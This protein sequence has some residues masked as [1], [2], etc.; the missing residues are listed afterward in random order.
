MAHVPS[1]PCMI[2]SILYS[3]F[4]TPKT[5][6]DLR[7]TTPARASPTAQNFLNFILLFWKIW[8]NRRLAPPP[9]DCR[10]LLWG[11]LGPSLQKQSDNF[12]CIV[13]I[14]ERSSLLLMAAVG[15]SGPTPPYCSRPSN[16][17]EQNRTGT[18]SMLGSSVFAMTSDG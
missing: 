4:I 15:T 14:S 17:T 3:S 9:R 6:A 16:V 1:A 11:I 5:V 13:I 7:G 8:Q 12:H 18:C 10:P 2:H